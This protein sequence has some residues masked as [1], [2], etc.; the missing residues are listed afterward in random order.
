[1]LIGYILCCYVSLDRR[2]KKLEMDIVD[3]SLEI[4][5]EIPSE[6]QVKFECHKTLLLLQKKIENS[7]KDLNSRKRAR[8]DKSALEF[9]A[10]Q[11]KS[12]TSVD[13]P[14]V[15][16]DQRNARGIIMRFPV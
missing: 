14:L 2:E 1:M 15:Y 16:L 13:P 12:L 5:A 9:L 4:F 10:K 3:F 6:V 8:I 11:S 7:R